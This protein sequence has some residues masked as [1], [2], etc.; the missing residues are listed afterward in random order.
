MPRADARIK[1]KMIDLFPWLTEQDFKDIV[2]ELRPKISDAESDSE[3]DPGLADDRLEV[4]IAHHIAAKREALDMDDP[5]RGAHFYTKLM[6][7][8]FTYDLTKGRA[9]D[10]IAC[11]PRAHTKKWRD[12]FHWPHKKSFATLEHG[13]VGAKILAEEWVLKATFYFLLFW[14]DILGLDEFE[15]D[16]ITPEYQY[17][18][19]AQFLDWATTVD[20]ACDSWVRIT[21]VNSIQPM[22]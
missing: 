7:G 11:L 14:D 4:D 21:E 22:K 1:A 17:T 19:S 5:V 2:I 6:C 16:L 13:E 18:P 15:Y 20:L 8:R 3:S 10:G 9:W 12:K